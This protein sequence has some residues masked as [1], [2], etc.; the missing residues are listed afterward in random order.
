MFDILMGIHHDYAA[1][2]AKVKKAMS[3]VEERAAA[4]MK[5]LEG[6]IHA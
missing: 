1:A 2:E 4:Q 5:I 6:V 3:Y